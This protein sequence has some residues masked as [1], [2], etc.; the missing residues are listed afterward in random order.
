MAF[1]LILR[2]RDGEHKIVSRNTFESEDAAKT[3]A[4]SFYARVISSAGALEAMALSG[5]TVTAEPA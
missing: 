5:G 1:K 3:E 4:P 2:T